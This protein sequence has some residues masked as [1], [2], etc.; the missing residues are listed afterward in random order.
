MN[1]KKILEILDEYSDKNYGEIYIDQHQE[2]AKDLLKYFKQQLLIH[3]V[4]HCADELEPIKGNI[5]ATAFT[6]PSDH[7]I[8]TIELLYGHYKMKDWKK[9]DKIEL[10]HCG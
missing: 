6:T 2:I 1:K 5:T 4:S 10:K 9:G 8:V 3:S 7:G